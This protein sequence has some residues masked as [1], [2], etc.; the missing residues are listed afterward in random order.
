MKVA[1]PTSRWENLA[2]NI[3]LTSKKQKPREIDVTR[4]H[5]MPEVMGKSKNNEYSNKLKEYQGSKKSV[6][7]N[8]KKTYSQNSNYN[9]HIAKNV[10]LLGYNKMGTSEDKKKMKHRRVESKI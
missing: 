7:Q 9:D 2:K 10:S 5:P 4:D 1:K 6:G 8:P 3:K